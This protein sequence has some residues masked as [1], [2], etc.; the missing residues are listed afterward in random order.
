[1]VSH[2]MFYYIN[3]LCTPSFSTELIKTESDFFV[4][5]VQTGLPRRALVLAVISIDAVLFLAFTDLICHL[6][7]T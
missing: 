5:S 6:K 3:Q 4:R 7:D 2:K 1:M